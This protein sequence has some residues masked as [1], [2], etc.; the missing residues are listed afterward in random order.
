MIDNYSPSELIE[1]LDNCD[2]CFY[3]KE[4]SPKY[5]KKLFV[6]NHTGLGKKPGGTW[7]ANW[8]GHTYQ[9]T[10]HKG[11]YFA[12]YKNELLTVDTKDVETDTFFEN[13]NS[14]MHLKNYLDIE[15]F[16]NR[17]DFKKIEETFNDMFDRPPI[18]SFRALHTTS[19]RA[20]L[21]HQKKGVL[22][23]IKRTKHHDFNYRNNSAPVFNSKDLNILLNKFEL[24]LDQRFPTFRNFGK[25]KISTE[26]SC[27]S[28]NE[29][30]REDVA[31]F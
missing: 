25:L 28:V 7:V 24:F 12:F 29:I 26:P 14:S 1:V 20:K 13:I 3:F 15:Y 23:L 31:D 30:Y 19:R 17:Y 10:L 11:R 18:F 2:W 6:L 22:E 8:T 4:K 27:G 21:E 9:L 5:D 16:D